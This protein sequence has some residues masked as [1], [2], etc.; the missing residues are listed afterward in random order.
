MTDPVDILARRI[1]PCT[2]D[3]IKGNPVRLQTCLH[4]LHRFFNPRLTQLR[5]HQS[6]LLTVLLGISSRGIE[7]TF[8]QGIILPFPVFQ[9]LLRPFDI[10]FHFKPPILVT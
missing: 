9:D 6:C 7:N 10:L 2:I 1:R 4:L 8:T 5:H 3:Q